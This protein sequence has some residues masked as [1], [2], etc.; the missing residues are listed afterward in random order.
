MVNHTQC[1]GR[2]DGA[3]IGFKQVGAHSG[4]IAHIVPHVIGDNRRISRIIFRDPGLHF[5]HQIGAHI[6]G[7][8]IYT[9]PHT[10][11]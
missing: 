11:K 7:F 5:A 10:G 6:G 2:D 3:H 4:H 1:Q 9:A 8:R